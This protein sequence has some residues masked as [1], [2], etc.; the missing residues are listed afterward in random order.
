M[1]D[2]N[3]SRILAGNAAGAVAMI[4]IGLVIFIPSGLCT[5]II[6]GGALI[7][8]FVNPRNFDGIAM[9]IIPLVVGGPFVAGGFAL[10][11]SGI[12]RLRGR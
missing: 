7:G 6:G 10:I 1:D 4:I 12:K 9:I 3:P 11:W 2:P 5:G 8:M